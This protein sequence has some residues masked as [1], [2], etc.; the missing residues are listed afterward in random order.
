MKNV[1]FSNRQRLKVSQWNHLYIYLI[2]WQRRTHSY[3]LWLLLV[4]ILNRALCTENSQCQTISYNCVISCAPI[5]QAKKVV[6]HETLSLK[7]FSEK[8]WGKINYKQIDIWSGNKKLREKKECQKKANWVQLNFWLQSPLVS[9]HI[10]AG[11]S[12]PK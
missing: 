7:W 5:Q 12:F 8:L 3:N 4:F 9:N 1:D 6:K 2:K 11:T 10:S